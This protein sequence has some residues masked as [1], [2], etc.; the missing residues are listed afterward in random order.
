[1]ETGSMCSG[2]H[3]P[4]SYCEQ[5]QE[6]TNRDLYFHDP[7]HIELIRWQSEEVEISPIDL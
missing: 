6:I 2:E 1:M 7:E 5:Q 4:Q 3:N